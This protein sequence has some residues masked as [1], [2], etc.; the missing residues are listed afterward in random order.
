MDILLIILGILC[1]IAG[2]AGCFLPV[3]PGPPVAYAGLLLLHF[4]DKVQYSTTQLLVWL[5]IVIVM[6]VLDYFVPMLGSKY[7][8][9]S[10]WGTRGCL[11]GTIVGLFF[12]PWGIILGPFLGAF[13]GELLG[14][15]KARQ[16]L[17]SGLGSLLGFLLGTVLKCVVC[18]YFIYQFVSNLF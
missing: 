11:V 9:G 8:G 5:F 2:L 7:S 18:G 3:L 14:G 1:L 15:R 6:Q 4:T 17:K 10:R 13:I 16:A 12:M